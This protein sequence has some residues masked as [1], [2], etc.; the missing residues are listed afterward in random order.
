M[1]GCDFVLSAGL[2]GQVAM[3]LIRNPSTILSKIQV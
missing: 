3:A 1:P 2:S